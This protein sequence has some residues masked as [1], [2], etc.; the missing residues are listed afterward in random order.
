MQNFQLGSVVRLAS[1]IS[2][3]M[4]ISKFYGTTPPPPPIIE[5]VPTVV[6]PGAPAPVVAAPEIMPFPPN[7]TRIYDCECIWF[8][9]TF[10]L[11][12]GDFDF[13]SLRLS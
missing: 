4:T 8:D 12:T 9:K 2:N 6:I 11:Q 7:P 1:D 5:T 13:T 10:Y 3:K